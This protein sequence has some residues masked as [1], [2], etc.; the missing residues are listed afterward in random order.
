MKLSMTYRI[1]TNAQY[2]QARAYFRDSDKIGERFGEYRYNAVKRCIEGA[3]P[4]HVNDVLEAARGINRYRETAK[5]IKGL[6]L[7]FPGDVNR[8]FA[9]HSKLTKAQKARLAYLRENWDREL[10]GLE[11]EAD[12][13]INRARPATTW[14]AE[15]ALEK[16]KATLK[17]HGIEDPDAFLRAQLSPAPK[18]KSNVVS[19]EQQNQEKI[20][21]T[22]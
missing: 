10:M 5:I 14:N 1:L 6:R 2:G 20:L 19:L 4:T 9:P 3:D 22:A 12:E 8:G 7:P 18:D 13:S 15:A 17:R 21:K 11:M 16:F